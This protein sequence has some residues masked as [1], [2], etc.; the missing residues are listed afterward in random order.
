MKEL[1]PVLK[2]AI[3]SGSAVA[4]WYLVVIQALGFIK[5]LMAYGFWILVG[6]GIYALISKAL[7]VPKK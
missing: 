4:I 7:E 3:E 1:V 6:K 2:Q 5:T